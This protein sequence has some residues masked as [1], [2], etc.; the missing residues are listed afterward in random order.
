MERYEEIR[1]RCEAATPGEWVAAGCDNTHTAVYTKD[2]YEK[3]ENG[4]YC[5]LIAELRRDDDTADPDQFNA[6][7]D[8]EF[9]A[10]SREDIPFLLDEFAA[11]NAEIERLTAERDA[12]LKEI[13]VSCA[14]CKHV[15]TF[16]KGVCR[17]CM[18]DGHI[19]H[20]KWE[21][22]GLEGTE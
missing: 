8:A 22:K 15:K 20:S 6:W 11:K 17:D 4:I 1:A 3:Y 21:W 5:Y 2:N 13:P 16:L 14:N 9:I 10:H 18:V 7:N 19:E 12:A